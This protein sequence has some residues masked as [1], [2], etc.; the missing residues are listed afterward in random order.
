[1]PETNFKYRPIPDV[2][3][4]NEPD[5]NRK[6]SNQPADQRRITRR[7]PRVQRY[8]RQP[9]PHARTATLFGLYRRIVASYEIFSIIGEQS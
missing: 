1:M 3:Q 9:N 2:Q 7:S 8:D 6:V 4:Q 5:E